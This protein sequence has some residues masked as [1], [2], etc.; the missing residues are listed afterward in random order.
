[1][2]NLG[3]SSIAFEL[4]PNANNDPIFKIFFAANGSQNN[5]HVNLPPGKWKVIIQDYVFLQ[6]NIF[7]ENQI[8]ISSANCILL[9]LL[10]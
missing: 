6:N 2:S 7:A 8:D 5:L 9:F 4:G 10:E 3:P 1:M